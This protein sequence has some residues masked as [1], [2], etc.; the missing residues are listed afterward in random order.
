MKVYLS[1]FAD[2]AS[3]DF[4]GQLD[5]LKRNNIKYVELRRIDGVNISKITSEKACEYKKMLDENGIKV[6][7]LGS[8]LAK[9]FY[10]KDI[11]SEIEMAEHL[12]DLSEIFECRNIRAFSFRSILKKRSSP[13]IKTKLEVVFNAVQKRNINYCLENDTGLYADVP[14]RITEILDYLPDMKYIYDPANFIISGC[15]SKDTLNLLCNRAYYFHIKDAKGKKIVPSG[16]G[17]ADIDRLIKMI[18][19]DCTCTV[20]PHLFVFRG[21]RGTYTDNYNLKTSGGKFDLAVDA[22]KKAL[23]ENGFVECDGYFEKTEVE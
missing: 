10:T 12:C 23:K 21:F 16:F 18:D 22:F 15:R 1:A 2:E 19:R 20:E 9:Q 5:A 8:P 6:W 13:A 17:D 3:K 11:A 14:E 4:Q 7:S